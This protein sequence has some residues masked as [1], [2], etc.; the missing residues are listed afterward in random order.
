M[1]PVMWMS[2]GPD[3]MRVALMR[4]VLLAALV[5]PAG[6]CTKH[7]TPAPNPVATVSAP[8]VPSSAPAL[9]EDD[10]RL[11]VYAFGAGGPLPVDDKG[12]VYSTVYLTIAS[13]RPTL[14]VELQSLGMRDALGARVASMV[15][16]GTMMRDNRPFDDNVSDG[17][18]VQ[19]WC[20]ARMDTLYA[21]LRKAGATW[22]AAVLVV[23]GER[24]TVEGA[25][26]VP[27][28]TG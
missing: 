22:F 15:S 7:D 17:G 13:K 18:T 19:L 24:R 20:S 14:H 4:A 12:N 16:P 10:V 3:E 5:A 28:V 26:A 6:A 21:A 2:I 11:A 9:V 23:A 25:I 27:T 1:V 8:T